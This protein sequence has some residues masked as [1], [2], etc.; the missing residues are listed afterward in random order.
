LNV[1]TKSL[2]SDESSQVSREIQY[3]IVYWSILYF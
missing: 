1:A 3:D 2:S